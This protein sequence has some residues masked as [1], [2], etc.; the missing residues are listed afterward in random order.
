MTFILFSEEL[1]KRDN[2]GK[3]H[4]EVHRW[5]VCAYRDL[6]RWNEKLRKDL[7]EA[8]E[9]AKNY[10]DAWREAEHVNPGS[11]DWSMDEFLWEVEE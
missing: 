1:W 6:Q 7:K 10:R 9:L 3:N 4:P 2:C 5:A 8:R 11:P